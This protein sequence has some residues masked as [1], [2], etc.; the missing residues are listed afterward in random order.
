MSHRAQNGNR[1]DEALDDA[2]VEQLLAGRYEGDAADL[3]A[4]R[5]LLGEVRSLAE[6]PA[7]P[8]SASLARILSDPSPAS[9]GDLRTMS[10]RVFRDRQLAPFRRRAQGVQPATAARHRWRPSYPP[11]VAA[12]VVAVLV[13]IVVGAGSARLLPG[14]TQDIVASI[15][16][17]MT[18]F[19]FPE[20]RNPETVSSKAPS[21]ETAT[22]SEE[23][24][25]RVPGDSSQPGAGEPETN[26]S[27][28]VPGDGTGSRS[29][30]GGVN[31]APTP[32]TTVAEANGPSSD[33]V[34]SLVPSPPPE[35]RGFSADLLG[36]MGAETAG[37]LDGGGKAAL[38]AHPGRDELCLTLVVSSIAPVTAVHL[39]AQS[40]GVSG[41]VV[42]AWTEPTA[43]ASAGCVRVTDQL[44]KKIR[45]Q[46]G[47]YYVDVHTTEFPNGALRGPLTR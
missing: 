32:A 39:H 37:D 40:T 46:P 19:D 42:A 28:W 2:T 33:G 31:A 38:D 6:R 29:Q 7:P 27:Q 44:I 47:E 15:V 36:V 12:A 11:M 5:D 30:P 41:P 4:V 1:A 10:R 18:P 20:Q 34:I 43:G 23:P 35:R 13:A 45:K 14:P 24:T 8:P 3:V 22:P 25:A 9:G 16:R 26:G 17:A 21:P